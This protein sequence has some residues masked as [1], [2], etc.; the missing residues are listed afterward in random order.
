M[1][2]HR[3]G[4][5]LTFIAAKKNI[6]NKIL[7]YYSVSMGQ[8]DFASLPDEAKKRIPKYPIPVMRIGR[9]AV[10]KS[11]KGEGIGRDLLMDAFHR[12]LEV[13]KSIGVYA[14]V[15]DAKDDNAKSFYRRYGFLEFTDKPMVLFILMSTIKDTQ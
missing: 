9:L 7:G 15:V 1:Q 11:A 2:N 4:L 6:P 8:V 12:A 14:I 3:K 13:A 5:S 10:D